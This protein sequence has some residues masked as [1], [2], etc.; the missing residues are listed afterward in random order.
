MENVILP[1]LG[2]T[3]EEGTIMEW[4]VKVGDVVKPGDV[5]CEVETDKLTK[6]IEAKVGG[7]VKEI[8]VQKEETVPVQTVLA[9]IE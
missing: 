3:M 8:L 1:K 2:L 9:V 5:L 4:L 6:E 7:T